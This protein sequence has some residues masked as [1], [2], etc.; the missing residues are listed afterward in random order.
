VISRRNLLALLGVAGLTACS[1]DP[2]GE[3]A[4]RSGD[5]TAQ[6]LAA[7]QSL[8][9]SEV[10]RAAPDQR[11]ISSGVAA[12]TAFSAD[13]YRRLATGSRH[14]LVCSPYSVAQALAMTVQGAAGATARQILQVLH[15]GTDP[16]P[17]AVAAALARGLG[18][19]ELTLA[20]RSR[21]FPD[22][23][24]PSDRVELATANT[25]WGQQGLAWQRPFL[26][27]LARDFGTGMRQ[28]DYRKAADG[29][30]DLI[31]AWVSR[32][33]RERIRQ[34][35]P[36]GVLDAMTRLVLVN[37]VY[38][39]A[40]WNAPFPAGATRP[41]PFT[42]ADSGTVTVPMMSDLVADA[43]YVTGDGWAALDLPYLGGELAMAMI[44][45]DRG[46]FAEVEASLT[47]TLL[48]QVLGGFTRGAVRVGLPRWTTRTQVSLREVLSALG[49]TAAF[50]P[51]AADFTAIT[52]QER[53]HVSAV[54]HE[55]FVTVD[56][57]GTEAAAATA[58]AMRAMGML[59]ESH[60]F[61]ANRP[62]LYVIHDV[63]TG[64]PLF[65]GRVLDPT[66]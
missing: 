49:M 28:V 38:L 15:A 53:L 56:E 60:S 12:V 45:P 6:Q 17:S 43:G 58:V 47:P 40:P 10:S 32:Q 57:H 27:V 54:L 1:G 11:S 51:S 13:L 30:R 59:A 61:V 16:V 52:R 42:R 46:R 25:L 22:S 63:P 21:Q 39:K 36:A 34:V 35:I 2:A 64:T 55:G 5:Q 8:S 24:G 29:A 33:T 23:Q 3:H 4:D 62:F 20:A 65:I 14:N 26:D 44:L 48:G 50:D 7:A 37:A 41:Q 66:A 9:R 19:L 18:G 31:N